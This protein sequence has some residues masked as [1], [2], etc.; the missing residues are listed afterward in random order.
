MTVKAPGVSADAGFTKSPEPVLE[1]ATWKGGPPV[2]P[3]LMVCD[4]GA[5]P[6]LNAN[7]KESVLPSS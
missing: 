1:A 2:L 5:L 3:T 4:A 7:S 6:I